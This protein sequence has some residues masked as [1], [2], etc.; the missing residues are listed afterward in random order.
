MLK[1]SDIEKKKY[2]AIWKHEGYR[3]NAP[4]LKHI[5]TAIEAL[6]M[7][8]GSDVYDFGIGTGLGALAL[9]QAGMN[10]TGVDIAANCL[11]EGIDVPVH[12][13]ALWD[14]DCI[15]L[16]F[17]ICCD[18]MEHIPPEMVEQT[19]ERI[20]RHVNKSCY[21]AIS[22]RDETKGM[23]LIG[24]KLHLTIK[25]AEWWH[26]ELEKHFDEV[27]LAAFGDEII[28]ICVKG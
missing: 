15:P 4:A 11:N 1:I 7:K 9:Q 10:V 17:G 2:R 3:A 18:V 14:F 22:M 12:V 23:M 13:S 8:A 5:G 26:K 25:P 19:V 27:S 16:D 20:A 24:E 28:A 6:G 21:F